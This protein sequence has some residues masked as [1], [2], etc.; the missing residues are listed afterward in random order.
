MIKYYIKR[1]YSS[2]LHLF[3]YASEV[4]KYQGVLIGSPLHGNLGDHA[5]TLAEFGIFDSLNIRIMDYPWIDYLIPLYAAVTPGNHLIMITGGGFIGGLWEEEEKRVRRVIKAFRKNRIIVLPQTVYYDLSTD[6]GRRFFEVSRRVFSSHPDL[7]M[8]LREKYSYGFMK[9]NCP[10]IEIRLVPDVTFVLDRKL[11][12]E[13]HGG[14]LCLRNDK[15][16][17]LTCAD[18][19]RLKAMTE[20]SYDECIMTDTCIDGRVSVDE[21][22]EKVMSLLDRFASSELVITDRLHGMIFSAIT[23]TPC[24][25]LPSL[26]HKIK[27]CYEWINDLGYVILAESIDDIPDLISS[28]KK[29]TPHYDKERITHLLEPLIKLLSIYTEQD[30]DH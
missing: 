24:I 22:E 17:T 21:R 3:R 15:E 6:E 14:M 16:K 20:S 23:G 5:I 18:R 4:R 29:V 12:G 11:N 10:D 30:A 2:L 8:F 7:I 13:R 27:G 9:D 25:V 26:S 28:L 19:S 1:V